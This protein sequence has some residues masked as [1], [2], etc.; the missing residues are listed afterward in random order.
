MSDG[1]R[2]Q[3]SVSRAEGAVYQT[4]LRLTALRQPHR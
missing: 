4:G 2:Q 1:G 3:H